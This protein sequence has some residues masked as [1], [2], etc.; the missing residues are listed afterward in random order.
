MQIPSFHCLLL[1]CLVAFLKI[2][3]TVANKW[4]EH[5]KCVQLLNTLC[6]QFYICSVLLE[7]TLVYHCGKCNFPVTIILWSST[8]PP[9]WVPCVPK[10]TT[11][12]QKTFLKTPLHN[13]HGWVKHVRHQGMIVIL[14]FITCQQLIFGSFENFFISAFKE[15]HF[16][17]IFNIKNI[18]CQQK[19]IPL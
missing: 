5:M 9:L 18:N 15:R 11:A 17:S 13:E 12:M 14:L 16:P 7:Y 4:E 6:N 10:I 8:L 2:L 19:V 3:T 1:I